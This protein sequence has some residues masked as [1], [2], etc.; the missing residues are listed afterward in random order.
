MSRQTVD[1]V[2]LFV[3]QSFALADEECMELA[4]AWISKYGFAV[5]VS[6]EVEFA[7]YPGIVERY[8]DNWASI[9]AIGGVD[10]FIREMRKSCSNNGYKLLTRLDFDRMIIQR[11]PLNITLKPSGERVMVKAIIAAI[12]LLPAFNN[13][14][15]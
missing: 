13:S 4:L 1:Q 2:K 6:T 8:F 3:D 10:W 7:F 9:R 14:L 5:C 15:T 11:N 12:P